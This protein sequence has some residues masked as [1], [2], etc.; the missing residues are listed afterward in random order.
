MWT[1]QPP[2]YLGWTLVS[3]N[4]P[5][6]KVAKVSRFV[7]TGHRSLL[8]SLGEGWQSPPGANSEPRI[9][10][11]NHLVTRIVSLGPSATILLNYFFITIFKYYTP[12]FKEHEFQIL[13]SQFS[14]FFFFRSSFMYGSHLTK[15]EIAFSDPT[16]DGKLFA[17]KY[18]NTPTFLVYNFVAWSWCRTSDRSKGSGYV[19]F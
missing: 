2:S 10:K 7:L 17:T 18:F 19:P 13:F 15:E 1:I 9:L 5:A 14:R 16:P 11:C 6:K 4:K 8:A 12:S 3:S